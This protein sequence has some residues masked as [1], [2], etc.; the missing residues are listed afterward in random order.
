MN[1]PMQ[2]GF[3]AWFY[4]G[5]AGINPTEQG[6]GFQTIEFKPYLTRHMASASA[7]FD[8]KSGSI[9]SE[10]RQDGQTLKWRVVIPPNATGKVF[11]PIYESGGSIQVN[12]KQIKG[13]KQSDGFSKIGEFGSGDYLIE[14]AL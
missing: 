5:I 1:H 9:I 6:P 13:E 14:L 11:V 12:G 7:S 8:S 10:W 4:S 3:D 2:S